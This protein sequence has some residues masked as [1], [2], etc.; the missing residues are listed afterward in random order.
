M[1]IKKNKNKNPTR[2]IQNVTK[3]LT[4]I[5]AYCV[6]SFYGNSALNNR[7]L[8]NKHVLRRMIYKE[9]G[10]KKRNEI[11]VRTYGEKNI[12]QTAGHFPLNAVL[13]VPA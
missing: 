3:I 4:T 2:T 7:G 5:S 10:K 13:D 11:N 1:N 6:I 9:T 12:L 8:H